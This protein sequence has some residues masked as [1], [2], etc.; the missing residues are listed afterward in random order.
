MHDF[1]FDVDGLGVAFTAADGTT[2]VKNNAGH[3]SSK[4]MQK[5]KDDYDL[6]EIEAGLE[7]GAELG[8]QGPVYVSKEEYD[9][10]TA[11]L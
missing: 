1:I 4:A 10:L 11:G 8:L 5:A 3:G 9:A 6:A 2:N 7:R